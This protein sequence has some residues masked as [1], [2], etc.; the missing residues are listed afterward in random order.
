MIL[1]FSSNLKAAK[2]AQRKIPVGTKQSFTAFFSLYFFPEAYGVQSLDTQIMAKKPNDK[3]TLNVESCWKG[4][5]GKLNLFKSCARR[6][7]LSR[8][9]Q[10][11]IRSL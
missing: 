8:N 7:R 11:T 6:I 10:P 3:H 1:L 9:D 5:E 2:I 4:S